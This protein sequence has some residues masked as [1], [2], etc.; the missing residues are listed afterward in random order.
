MLQI[1][2]V[3]SQKWFLMELPFQL[4]RL[5]DENDELVGKRSRFAQEI[6]EEFISLPD[7]IEVIVFDE[8]LFICL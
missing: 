6:Q 1:A 4:M 2:F 5:Q 3:W 7:N 8:Y